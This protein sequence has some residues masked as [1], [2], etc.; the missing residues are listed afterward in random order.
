MKFE[1]GSQGKRCADIAERHL[2]GESPLDIYP[3]HVIRYPMF[4][5]RQLKR[6]GIPE[7]KLPTNGI[8]RFKPPSLWELYRRLMI[9]TTLADSFQ[10]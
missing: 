5:W 10:L 4:D 2:R 1:R 6:W 3:A 9:A 8:V 7:E